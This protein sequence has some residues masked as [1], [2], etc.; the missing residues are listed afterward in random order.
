MAQT[1]NRQP[2]IDLTREEL[3]DLLRKEAEHVNYS[4]DAFLDEIKR[5]SQDRNTKAMIG[6]TWAIVALGFLQVIATFISLFK[7]PG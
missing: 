5:R 1:K 4:Y 3:T 2:L 6:L 7:H